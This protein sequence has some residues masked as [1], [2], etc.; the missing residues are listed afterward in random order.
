MGETVQKERDY[1]QNADIDDKGDFSSRPVNPGLENDKS[2]CVYEK[3]ANYFR[4]T[5][6]RGW[7]APKCEGNFQFGKCRFEFIRL[8]SEGKRTKML[9]KAFSATSS[10]SSIAWSVSPQRSA[11]SEHTDPAQKTV[12][13]FSTG[14][15]PA[16]RAID[17][18]GARRDSES[19]CT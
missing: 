2:E 8:E 18:C 3:G 17:I 14:E 6:G 19:H 13:L 4:R 10:E 12:S 16:M 1:Q 7:S 15:S 11:I 5:S 9:S